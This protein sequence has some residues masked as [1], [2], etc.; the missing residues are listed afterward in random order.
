[1]VF[2]L[3]CSDRAVSSGDASTGS[4]G[5]DAST[6]STSSTSSTDDGTTTS[7]SES[8]ASSEGSEITG[9][10]GCIEGT[11]GIGE[12]CNYLLQDCPEGLKCVKRLVE[13]GLQPICVPVDCEG[14]D[15]GE[16]CER[17]EIGADDCSP[18]TF[19]AT[20]SWDI[21]TGYCVDFC[22]AISD[23]ACADPAQLCVGSS[24]D[25]QYGCFPRCDPLGDACPPMTA[26]MLGYPGYDDEFAC[27]P[28][29]PDATGTTGDPCF[30]AYECAAGHVCPSWLD[31]GPGCDPDVLYG[32]CSEYC[33]L[34]GGVCSNPLHE[35]RPFTASVGV[36]GIP[37]GFDWC[38]GSFEP[39]PGLCPPPDAEPNIP[40]CSSYDD[41]ACPG[42][43]VHLGGGHCWCVDPCETVDDCPIPATGTGDP[44][45]DA[46]FGGCT[47]LCDDDSEC[48]KGMDCFSVDGALRCLWHPDAG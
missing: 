39:P 48:P 6:G 46:K 24:G 26:C 2:A 36:C 23:F 22:L 34:D 4:T 12:S 9:S 16:P 47:V 17:D 21:P 45:C 1:M 44:A 5:S 3:G 28:I 18:T 32:C 20:A 38:D 35:C 41:S 42:D 11:E 29:P 7:S 31:Y 40:W 33:D 37:E 13:D 25:G 15:A 27:Y 43:S 19:C 10:T 8:S 30:S 14:H